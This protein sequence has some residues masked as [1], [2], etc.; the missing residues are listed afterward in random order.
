VKPTEDELLDDDLP[1]LLEVPAPLD[2]PPL[3][4]LPPDEPTPPEDA[5]LLE[6]INGCAPLDELVDEPVKLP[7]DELL[8]DDL[9]PLLEVPAPLDAP[10][11]DDLSP[12]K[13]TPPED[14]PLL[15]P[16]NGCAPLDELVDEPVKPPE[17]ELIESAPLNP[18]DL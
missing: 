2:A 6:P 4:D 7:E 9:P 15:E 10:T 18:C 17:D 5:P 11:L 1:P 8:D 13:P 16:I 14:A 12:D 3:D